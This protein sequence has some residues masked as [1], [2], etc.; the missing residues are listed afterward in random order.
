MW[1]EVKYY[2]DIK[3]LTFDEYQLTCSHIFSIISNV[4]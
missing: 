4:G 2:S 1:V 3:L